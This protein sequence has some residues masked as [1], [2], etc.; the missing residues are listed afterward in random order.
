M[1]ELLPKVDSIHYHE[2]YYPE[3]NRN[4]KVTVNYDK[5]KPNDWRIVTQYRLCNNGKLWAPYNRAYVLDKDVESTV[6]GYLR[7][8]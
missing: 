6:K 2:E 7:E 5:S 8:E 4:I 1:A 3:D